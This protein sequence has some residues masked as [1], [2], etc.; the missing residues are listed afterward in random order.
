MLTEKSQPP[1]RSAREYALARMVA[2]NFD[3]RAELRREVEQLRDQLEEARERER[4]RIAREMHDSTVQELVAISLMLRRLQDM[5]VE[6]GA[7]KVLDDARETLAQTQQDLR[8]LSYLLHPPI[9]D[10][11][12]L[13]VA[14][15][16]LIRGLSNRMRLR[17]DL[18]CDAP[19]MRSSV[20][21]ESAL[22]RVVQESLINIH[23]HAAATRAVVS[24]F[25]EPGLL[26][27]EIEDD[28]N[29]AG[30]DREPE[31]GCGVGIPGMQ[32]RLAQLGGTLKVSGAQR[33]VL[34]RAEVPVVEADWGFQ[35]RDEFLLPIMRWKKG[36]P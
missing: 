35:A 34:V 22:Y 27:L 26:V 29:G 36:L 10:D 8:T 19:G 18:V 33:G 25:R 11:E 32:A 4:R 7:K 24:Y 13:V 3:E 16:T 15:K 14:L 1:R 12:G 21:V 6:P 2:D 30:T 5:V 28:G 17:I 20:E 23:K 9:L 31:I